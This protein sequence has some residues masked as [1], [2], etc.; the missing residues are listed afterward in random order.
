MLER[1]EMLRYIAISGLYKFNDQAVDAICESMALNKGLRLVDFKRCTEDFF[2]KVEQGVNLFR[3]KKIMFLHSEQWA[4]V[5]GLRQRAASPERYLQ[6]SQ[7]D[8]S[9]ALEFEREDWE[10]RRGKQKRRTIEHVGED[11]ININTRNYRA[12]ESE[13]KKWRSKSVDEVDPYFLQKSAEKPQ[14]FGS[15]EESQ[16]MYSNS[17][18]KQYTP[19]R[20]A[21]NQRSETL[22]SAQK[23]LSDVY[24]GKSPGLRKQVQFSQD[25]KIFRGKQE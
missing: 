15:I 18:K 12:E 19:L 22:N 8:C 14:H 3:E 17:K 4:K 6:A 5:R 7:L 20:R 16:G 10:R 1:N 9:Q 13:S 21:S 24:S 23:D 11:K 2:E 25:I